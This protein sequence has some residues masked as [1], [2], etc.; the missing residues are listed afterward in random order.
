M[1]LFVAASH[2]R[3]RCAFKQ[4]I[5]CISSISKGR[6]G[7]QCSAAV[8]H[9]YWTLQLSFLFHVHC[10]SF[11]FLIIVSSFSSLLLRLTHLLPPP[12]HFLSLLS[13]PCC[14]HVFLSSKWAD[15]FSLFFFFRLHPHLHKG[16]GTSASNCHNM[17]VCVCVCVSS[18]YIT[19]WKSPVFCCFC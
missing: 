9:R 18:P 3:S 19:L 8:A 15:F 5:K 13:T 16:A 1:L 10:F 12:S 6:V 17:S 2:L 11:A 14:S 4:E 7:D